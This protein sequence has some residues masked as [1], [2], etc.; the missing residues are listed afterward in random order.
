MILL[1]TYELQMLPESP[2]ES[3]VVEDIL[4]KL[5]QAFEHCKP[6]QTCY[7]LKA[8]PE[9]IPV[10]YNEL[11]EIATTLHNSGIASLH[12]VFTPA[13]FNDECFQYQFLKDKS[14]CVKALFAPEGTVDDTAENN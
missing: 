1:F 3:T 12:F 11:N 5:M 7:F 8:A 2:V 4:V 14:A 9:H 13:D 10:L 6:L